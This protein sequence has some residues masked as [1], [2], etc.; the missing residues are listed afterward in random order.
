MFDNI[1]KAK[2]CTEEYMSITRVVTQQIS[3]P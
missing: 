1:Q 2:K 3:T